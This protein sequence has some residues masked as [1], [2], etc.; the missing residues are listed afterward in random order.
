MRL[1]NS[2]N[3]AGF[4]QVNKLLFVDARRTRQ[5]ASWFFSIVTVY[6]QEENSRRHREFKVSRLQYLYRYYITARVL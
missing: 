3:G 4:V 2:G 6:V 5:S 1:R